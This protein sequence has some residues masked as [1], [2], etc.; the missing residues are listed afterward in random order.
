MLP[1]LP[2]VP[3]PGVDV[4]FGAVADGVVEVLV[5]IEPPPEKLLPVEPEVGLVLLPGTFLLVS[6]MMISF[7]KSTIKHPQRMRIQGEPD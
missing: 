5:P 6:T 7:K 3:L 1:V 2:D 4:L